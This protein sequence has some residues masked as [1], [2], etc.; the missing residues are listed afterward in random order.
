MIKQLAEEIAELAAETISGAAHGGVSGKP[1]TPAEGQGVERP[2][3][4]G[5]KG[6]GESQTTYLADHVGQKRS[7]PKTKQP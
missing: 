2:R 6:V 7:Y 1:S 3:N 4:T 5:G